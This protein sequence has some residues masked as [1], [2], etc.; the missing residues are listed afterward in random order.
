MSADAHWRADDL[1]RLPPDAPRHVELIDGAL[2]V[3]PPQTAAHMRVVNSLLTALIE[4]APDW[5]EI[6]RDMT[7]RLGDRQCPEPDLLV[8][9]DSALDGDRTWVAPDDV[10]L[11]IEVMSPESAERDSVRKPQLYAEAGIRHFWRVDSVGDRPVLFAYELAGTGYLPTG[12]HREGM[13]VS[14]PFPV[15]LRVDALP[16]RP[17]VRRG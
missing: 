5:L 3:R 4:Q 9:A 14:A 8:M 15:T 11:V 1:D 13:A 6:G 12:V 10:C 7:I 17:P 16:D 2:V